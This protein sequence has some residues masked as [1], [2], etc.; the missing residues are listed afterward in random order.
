[1]KQRRGMKKMLLLWVPILVVL[2]ALIIAVTIVANVFAV[3]LDTYVGKG[4]AELV[5]PKDENGDPIEMDADFYEVKYDDI[6]EAR[7]ASEKVAEEIADEG[8][9]LLKNN[10]TLP[11]AKNSYVTA[12]GRGYVDPIYGGVGSGQMPTDGCVAPHDGLKTVFNVN[13]G[14]FAALTES[15]SDVIRGD[16]DPTAVEDKNTY[17]IGEFQKKTYEALDFT[18]YTDAVIVFIS[19]KGAEGGDLSMNLK[20]D[21]AW[22][23]S[24][25]GPFAGE[26]TETVN[27]ADD[28]HQLELSKEERDM[29]DVAKTNF[30]NV[31]VVI[32]SSNI[33]E[34]GE[35]E[36]D[37]EIDGIVWMGGPGSRGNVSVAK[38]LCGDV[39]PSG[40][41]VDTWSADFTRDPTFANYSRNGERDWNNVTDESGTKISFVEYEEG[42]YVGYKYFETMYSE[43][44]EGGDA[45]Y[46]AWRTADGTDDTGVVYPFGYGLSYASFD[47]SFVGQ[48]SVTDGRVDIT[49]RVENTHASRAG[50]DAVQIYFE[51]P[52][53]ETDRSMCIE[54]ATKNLVAFAKTAEI[55]AGSD[56]EI[57]LSF[58]L[59]DMASYCTTVENS[60][61]TKGGYMLEAGEYVI[62]LGENAHDSYATATITV[63]E[64]IWYTGND[65]RETDRIAQSYMNEDGTYR[66]IPKAAM[67][68]SSAG[69]VAAHNLFQ[70]VTD[71]MHSEG[72]TP[73][74]RANGFTEWVPTTPAGDELTASDYVV[75]EYK[76]KDYSGGALADSSVT[77]KPA[78][79]ADHGLKLSDLR[80]KDYYDPLWDDLLDQLTQEDYNNASQL[81][82]SYAFAEI[83]SVGKPYNK[84]SDGPQGLK[85]P[86]TP[87]G[88]AGAAPDKHGNAWPTEPI[89]AATFNV[90]LARGYGECVGDEAMQLGFMGWYGPGLNIHRSPFA[91]RNYEYYSEDGFL[92]GRMGATVIEA[93]SSKGVICYIKHYMLNDQES[94]RN[95]GASWC[96][97]Q[98]M[99]EIYLKAFELAVKEPV[100][101]V[102]YTNVETGEL[103]E[104]QMRSAFGLMTSYNRVGATWVGG[105][106]AAING[107]LRT[108]WGF[109]G[110]VIT[111]FGV[112]LKYMSSDQAHYAGGDQYLGIPGFSAP[113]Q[114]TTS[115]SAMWSL[116]NSYKNFFYAA[117]HS[118]IMNGVPA[119]A[120]YAYSMS[121][122]AVW[123]L[124]ANIVIYGFIIGMTTYL[125]IR[126][127]R[128][129]K[130]NVQEA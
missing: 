53:T 114:D 63:P 54:K 7:T 95:G 27:Y 62:H 115:P 70:D 76:L 65:L 12:L 78:L 9:V 92:S 1:M 34:V 49:V 83:E 97:E 35:L 90:D 125:A 64:T 61:G 72:K 104:K 105:C 17:W 116:R 88:G 75:E 121:P 58:A 13:E 122:W 10:G 11:L 91:G 25:N 99:R 120:A 48:P 111:D 130:S 45:W 43:L 85:G 5:M 107:V 77:E 108:E 31:I 87:T 106:E 109:R 74:T 41:L 18:G 29:L 8:I 103:G 66:D 57:A 86:F 33:M 123:L 14:A 51:P 3:T 80:G 101:T 30:E 55:A 113:Q 16:S 118:N 119:G 67:G 19:R 52:Y 47:Q 89:V 110:T 24:Y 79:G 38:I 20:D 50:K 128:N 100:T 26:H 94:D 112:A 81:M 102:K 96:D 6:F 37:D 126:F 71:Y 4:S 28:Q 36:L 46:D 15:V 84:D 117:A 93:A 127:V 59:E 82:D 73:L 22:H 44:G 69:F 32:S 56:T 40:H 124:I 2:L 68:D 129:K 42:I 23:E 60:D 39:V 21:I 98:A